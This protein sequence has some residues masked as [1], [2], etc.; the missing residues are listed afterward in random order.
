MNGNKYYWLSDYEAKLSPGLI[1]E[2]FAN[3]YEVKKL[4]KDKINFEI[5]NQKSLQ[6][7]QSG[8][9]KK[10]VTGAFI[11]QY[12]SKKDITGSTIQMERLN[13]SGDSK[14]VVVRHTIE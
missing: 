6:I 4:S 5:F 7:V 14:R 11:V 10:I 9:V 2:N 13:I 12:K 8:P 3:G 1:N